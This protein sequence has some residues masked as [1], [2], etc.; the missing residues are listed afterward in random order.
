MRVTKRPAVW[1]LVESQGEDQQI[2]IQAL[3]DVAPGSICYIATDASEALRILRHAGQFPDCIFIDLRR[4]GSSEKDLIEKIKSMREFKDIP[5]IVHSSPASRR[6]IDDLFDLGATGVQTK[7]VND[8][9]L[10]ELVNT[11]LE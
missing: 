8:D 1:L 5:I 2:F 11:Y 6:E 10:L 9:T 4:H 7:K 3:R